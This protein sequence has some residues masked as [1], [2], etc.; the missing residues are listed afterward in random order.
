MTASENSRRD[1]SSPQPGEIYF[2]F[3]QLG[4]YVKVSAMDAATGAEVS[5]VGPANASQADLQRLAKAK[6]MRRLARGEG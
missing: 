4:A 5:V 1:K 6:L 2:E 3:V